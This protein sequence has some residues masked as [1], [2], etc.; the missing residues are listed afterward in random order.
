MNKISDYSRISLAYP[1]ILWYIEDVPMRNETNN[2]RDET[3]TTE[4]KQN[5][6]DHLND[7]AFNIRQLQDVA[8][9]MRIAPQFGRLESQL[10]E[11][12]REIDNLRKQ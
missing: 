4:Q 12:Y 3:M 8:M 11:V 9:G 7:Q 1:A 5:R 6:I 10:L 2:L